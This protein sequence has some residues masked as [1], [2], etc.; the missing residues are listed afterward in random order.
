ME[1]DEVCDDGVNDG[2]YGGCE[3]DCAA[4]GPF[5]G[6]GMVDGPE[7]CDDGDD[8]QGNGCNSDCVPSG[9]ELWTHE[10][11]QTPNDVCVAIVTSSSDHLYLAARIDNLDGGEF[12]G[13][14]YAQRLSASGSVDWEREHG[15]L[16]SSTQHDYVTYEAA[17]AGDGVVV[18]GAHRLSATQN[19]V[20]TGYSD[21]HSVKLSAANGDVVWTRNDE[22]PAFP[23]GIAADD[24]GEFAV[25]AFAGNSFDSYIFR[26]S[27]GGNAVGGADITPGGEVSAIAFDPAGSFLVAMSPAQSVIQRRNAGFGVLWEA[28]LSPLGDVLALTVGE[29]S[30]VFAVGGGWVG[31]R[32]SADGSEVWTVQSNDVAA[33]G[34]SVSVATTPEGDIVVAGVRQGAPWVARL[35][36]EGGLRWSRSAGE[37]GAFASVGVRTDG[38]IVACGTIDGGGQ[39]DNI[40]VASYTP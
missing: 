28:T 29:G 5:C 24:D 17:D 9:L 30:D 15:P 8:T 7:E 12:A 36:P 4:F 40:F 22:G 1:G 19:P 11:H 37:D 33:L 3:S 14:F 38:S 39:G 16:A 13:S 27:E 20:V 26:V 31:R 35:D 34:S 25:A 18:T 32:A 10:E 21:V 6:D 23:V 2:S